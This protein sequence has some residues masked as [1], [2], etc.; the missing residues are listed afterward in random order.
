M[1]GILLLCLLAAMLAS[2]DR[3]H[4]TVIEIRRTLPGVEITAPRDTF[5]AAQGQYK[6]IVRMHNI[7]NT[8][9]VY[10]QIQADYLDEQGKLIATSTGGPGYTMKAGDSDEVE[11][12]WLFP[13]QRSLPYKVILTPAD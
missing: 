3:A 12:D 7:N 4:H 1:K 13:N 2:C 6:I 10:L 9:L 5:D 11:I 8:K